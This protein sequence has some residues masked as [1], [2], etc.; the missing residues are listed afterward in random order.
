MKRWR[1]SLRPN[2]R[3]SGQWF[4]VFLLNSPKLIKIVKISTKKKGNRD[5]SSSWKPSRLPNQPYICN[6][7]VSLSED[8]LSCRLS[9]APL[10]WR[11]TR[12]KERDREI[13]RV[14]NNEQ[15]DGSR[16]KRTDGRR[17]VVVVD[18][19]QRRQ[20]QNIHDDDDDDIK[21]NQ[22]MERRDQTNW[23]TSSVGFGFCSIWI[24]SEAGQ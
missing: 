19:L 15:V 5:K 17:Y 14:F 12:E 11:D 9:G 7:T 21:G 13:G 23:S 8:L 6:I 16:E 1:F 4:S 22:E 20:Q 2:L 24:G 3:R 18:E 10:T